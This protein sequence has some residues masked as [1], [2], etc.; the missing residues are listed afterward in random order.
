MNGI[1]DV[2]VEWTCTLSVDR[3]LG[4]SEK[5]AGLTFSIPFTCIHGLHSRFTCDNA[6][7]LDS[8]ALEQHC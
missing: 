7:V 8:A 4:G 6:A 1:N 5:W 2:Y 3:Y